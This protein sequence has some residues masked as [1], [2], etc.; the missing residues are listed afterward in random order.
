M[1]KSKLFK[2]GLAA[3]AAFLTLML[4]VRSWAGGE[5]LGKNVAEDTSKLDLDTGRFSRSAFRVSASLRAGYDDNVNTTSFDEQESAFL[6]FG[7]TVAYNFGSART[8][9]SLTTGGGLTYY[10]D[11]VRGNGN[12]QNYDANLYLALSALHKAT[13]RLSFA[14][15]VYASYQTQ[16]DF[17]INAALNRRSGN[18]F[19]TSDKFSMSYLWTPRFSTVTS[20]TLGVVNYD[21]STIGDFEDRFENTI[22]NELR[23]LVLPT[24]SLIAEHRVMFISYDV[25]TMR[26]SISNFALAGIDHSFSPRFS[27]SVR[28]GAEFHDYDE[29]GETTDPYF[30]GTLIYALGK[31]TSIS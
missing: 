11:D 30:E 9:L 23:F 13:A 26:D 17:S 19:Y 31:R 6:S 27:L 12:D 18:F 14:A 3:L 28:G 2:F 5:D 15:S 8:Q 21:D 1:R 20:Y 24:T 10:L 4:P 25:N 29:N 22:G 7:G 16:P